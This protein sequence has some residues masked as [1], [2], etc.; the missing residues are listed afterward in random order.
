MCLVQA[1]LGLSDQIKKSKIITVDNNLD[2][3]EGQAASYSFAQELED[4]RKNRRRRSPSSSRL[5]RAISEHYEDLHCLENF[6]T[7]RRTIIKAKES[8]QKGAE[9]LN[10]TD[11]DSY[12]TCLR[13]CCDTPYCNV[14]TFDQEVTMLIFINH[15]PNPDFVWP[16]RRS[17]FEFVLQNNLLGGSGKPV[18]RKLRLAKLAALAG[19]GRR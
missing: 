10:E 3:I 4:L 9:F 17:A 19:F 5:K 13:Y 12:E 15:N 16:S 2:G 18:Q 7:Q 14:A 11:V 8:Q 6:E 1:G